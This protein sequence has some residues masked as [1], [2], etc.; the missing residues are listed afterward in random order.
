MR[1]QPVG[2]TQGRAVFFGAAVI[3]HIFIG[4]VLATGLAKEMVV[5]IS[6]PMELEK[7]DEIKPDQKDEPPPP[8]KLDEPPPPF[9]PP[10]E[11][12]IAMPAG[13][14]ETGLT[15]VVQSVVSAPKS[16]PRRPNSKPEYPPVSRRNGEQGSVTLQLL[17]LET[18]RVGDAKI[19]QSS[20]FPLLDQAAVAHALRAWRFLPGTKDGKPVA[21]WHTVKVTF[22]LTDN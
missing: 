11:I 5:A 21:T 6:G 16:D 12:D 4:W 8:P 13:P 1:Y 3:F 18:G 9:V 15:Q 7:I 19:G 10:P 2:M 14:T 17:V 20:G 22:R